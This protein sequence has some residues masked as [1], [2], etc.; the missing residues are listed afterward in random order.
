MYS[1]VFFGHRDY[2]YERFQEWIESI[3]IDLIENYDVRQFYSGARG[4]FDW[5]CIKI[6]R[7]LKNR[8]P[9]IQCIRVW[10]YMP[11]TD[12]EE[13]YFDG[14]VYVLEKR[15]PPL[16]AILETNKQLLNKVE[17][18]LSGVTHSWGGAWSAAE[19]GRKQGKTIINVV[20]E[21]KSL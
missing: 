16:Y 13:E 4:N 8:Y 1:C 20:K 5:M 11:N 17:Y 18:I 9:Y 10:A 19:Y 15:V 2:H 3:L 7:D 21:E 12:E 6:I 14:S